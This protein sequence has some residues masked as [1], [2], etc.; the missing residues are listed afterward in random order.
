MLAFVKIL[1]HKEHFNQRWAT[2]SYGGH[3]PAASSF[4]PGRPPL[5]PSLEGQTSW[6]C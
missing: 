4:L 1:A 6:A 2:Q 3:D 5:L